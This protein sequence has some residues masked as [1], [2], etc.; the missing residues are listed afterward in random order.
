VQYHNNIDIIDQGWNTNLSYILV[1]TFLPLTFLLTT[2]VSSRLSL[3]YNIGFFKF[4]FGNVFSSVSLA[5]ILLSSVGT[6]SATLA[7]KLSKNLFY[8]D[9][10]VLSIKISSLLLDEN[11]LVSPPLWFCISFIAFCNVSSS[12]NK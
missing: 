8:F 12:S 1:S 4:N 10:S 7:F 9:S 2:T 3:L 11:G 5:K 6:G